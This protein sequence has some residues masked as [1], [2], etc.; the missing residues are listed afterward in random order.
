MLKFT[1]QDKAEEAFKALTGTS[2]GECMLSLE[3]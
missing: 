2:Y 1:N 3:L